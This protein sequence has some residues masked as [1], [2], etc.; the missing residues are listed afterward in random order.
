M[1]K[2]ELNLHTAALLTKVLM[3]FLTDRINVNLFL[4]FRSLSR[5]YYNNYCDTSTIDCNCWSSSHQGL[6][7][8]DVNGLCMLQRKCDMYWPK[9]GTETYGLVQVKLIKEDVLAMYT[10]RTLQILHTKVRF[11]YMKVSFSYQ[12]SIVESWAYIF[13]IRSLSFHW[14]CKEKLE[15]FFNFAWIAFCVL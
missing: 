12:I 6:L 14:C 11:Q 3:S 2:C 5:I 7:T 10:V 1:H 13:V 4:A 9:E 15:W 8:I